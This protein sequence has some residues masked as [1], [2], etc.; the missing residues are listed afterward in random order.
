M[1]AFV[2]FVRATKGFR[3]EPL[4][5]VEACFLFRGAVAEADVDATLWHVEIIW[6]DDLHPVGVAVDDLRHLHRVLDA[7]EPDPAARVAAERPAEDAVIQDLL[8]AGGR[9]DR[10]ECVD[11]GKLG[12]VKNGGAFAGVVVAHRG[13]H[14]AQRRGAG[15]VGVAEHVARAVD[16]RALGVPHA[17]DAVILAL[18]P[19]FRLLGAP[20]RGGGK[21]LVQ[22][23][24]EDD[25]MG[26]ELLLRA[27]HL[28]V[29][30]AKGRA[31]IAGDIARRVVACRLVAE[32]L[33]HRQTDERLG[34]AEQHRLF[35]QVEPVGQL[36]VVQC[37]AHLLRLQRH[38]RSAL[39]TQKAFSHHDAR[40]GKKRQNMIA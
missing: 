39:L 10:H 7:F 27:D 6:Q 2:D 40:N 18:A 38:Y 9:Q 13:D 3:R 25:V 23:G 24:I 34:A 36:D 14:A 5:V 31:A 20:E 8:H 29:H 28:L 12:M 35:R 37:H 33:H 30:P 17:K 32:F 22:A 11:E 21:V 19:E 4:V 1:D 26:V 15:H 16:A